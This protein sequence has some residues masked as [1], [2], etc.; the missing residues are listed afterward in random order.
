MRN[1][2]KIISI[3]L[4]IVIAT[5]AILDFNIKKLVLKQ[6]VNEDLVKNLIVGTSVKMDYSDQ[7]I[8]C[9]SE[10]IESIKIED[11]YVNTSIFGTTAS[12]SYS[13]ILSV[14]DLHI[15]TNGMLSLNYSSDSPCGWTVRNSSI[16]N[17]IDILDG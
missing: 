2:W 17:K 15:S 9:T 8:I 6:S 1:L 14:Y 4:I 3:S 10:N 13:V 12:V 11:V 7:H 5:C 16:S